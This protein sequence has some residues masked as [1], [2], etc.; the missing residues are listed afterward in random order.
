MFSDLR[1]I[2]TTQHSNKQQEFKIE[3]DDYEGKPNYSH[4]NM[5]Q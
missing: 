4:Y 5:N 2:N 1:K 3:R